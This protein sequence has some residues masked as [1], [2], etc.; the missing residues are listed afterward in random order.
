MSDFA[1][2]LAAEL[3]AH[4]ATTA[5]LSNCA[6]ALKAIAEAIVAALRAGNKVIFFGNGGSA[7]DA[8]HLAAE[9]VIRYRRE[10]RSLPSLALTTDT[11]MLTACGNDYGFD[12]VFARQLE[13]LANAGDIAIGITTSGNSA[14]VVA[15][16]QAA[17]DRGCITVAFVGTKNAGGQAAAISHHAFLAP[18]EVTARIQECHMLVG[19]ILCEHVDQLFSENP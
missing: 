13:S 11:S 7:A 19:H 14:N 12:R 4:Q 16:L 15:G 5:Q 17:R 9:F 6:P 10:R 1:N 8:Q 2:T 3:A 18:S